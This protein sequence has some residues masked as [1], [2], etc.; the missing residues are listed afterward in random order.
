MAKR[1]TFESIHH[2]DIIGKLT[3]ADRLIFRGY[4]GIA[5]EASFRTFLTVCGV[6]LK[7]FGEF[8]EKSTKVMKSHAQR[9]AADA[10]RPFIYLDSPHTARDELS[11]E[12]LARN[13]ARDDGITEGLICVLS[14]L[15]GCSAFDVRGNRKTKKLEVVRRYRKCLHFYFYYLHPEFGF[16]HVRVQSWFPFTIQVYVNGREWLCRQLDRQGIGYERYDN[17]LL[18]I[19]DLAAAQSLCRKFF[20]RRWPAVLD[21]FA[22]LVN[23]LLPRLH[24][25]RFGGYYWVTHQAEVATD[26]MFRDRPTLER[27]LPD[28]FGHMMTAGSAG[29]ALR[30]LGRKPSGNFTGEATSDLKR[31]PEG[32]RVKFRMKRNHIKMYDKMS[33]L[34]IETTI[35]NPREFRVWRSPIRQPEAGP[36]WMPLAKGVSNFWHYGQQGEKANVRF[37]D[38]LAAARPTQDAL[39]ELDRITRP[40]RVRG[41]TFSRFNPVDRDT[42]TLYLAALV[43][44]NVLNGFRNHDIAQFIDPNANTPAQKKRRR[45][46]VSRLIAKLRAHGLVAKVQRSRLYRVTPN[47]HRTLSAAIRYRHVDFAQAFGFAA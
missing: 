15:E 27:L 17:A 31:R 43:G 28:L 10:G 24:R 40:R 13:I 30:F 45:E 37:L 9:V 47:G 18:R 32:L 19:D 4:L 39:D 34:R 14:V 21:A 42:S 7:D 1:T 41:R 6:L 16:M 22:R 20:R 23:P 35:N 5:N 29:D 33:V 38:M 11:K 2:D 8:A 36:R 44:S 25:R 26:V 46:R 3:M 12:Q